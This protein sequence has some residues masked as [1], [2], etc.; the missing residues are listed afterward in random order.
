MGLNDYKISVAD[1]AG[2]GVQS[3]PDKLT[4]TAAEN[5]AVFDRLI[6]EIVKARLNGLIDELLGSGGASGI[7]LASVPGLTGA[8]TVQEALESIEQQLQEMTQGA[9]A[10]ASITAA[11]LASGAVTAEK[12]APEAVETEAILDE[13]V[14]EDK[15]AADA[16]TS[17]KLASGA[18]GTA[19]LLDGAVTAAKL[20]ADAVTTEK[21]ADG[22]VGT[23]QL[24]LLSVTGDRLAS[25][26]VTAAKL[27]AGAVTAEKLASGAVTGDKLASGAVSTR[28]TAQIGTVWTGSEAPYTQEIAV[29]GITATD[30]PIVDLLPS[31]TW[32]AAQTQIEEYGYI[33]RIE[34]GA[35]KITVYAAEPTTVA[36]DIQMEVLR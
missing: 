30:R 23:A 18:V 6:S 27:S 11:K 29:S 14:T 34:T 17:E 10:D 7:G 35:G 15:L 12:L 32:S 4:G 2:H 5:K 31:D 24:D 1:V 20:A 25:G 13:A 36:M 19:A 9:V 16:V 28:Y 8:E 21:L 3:A 26:A 33:Y 22:S